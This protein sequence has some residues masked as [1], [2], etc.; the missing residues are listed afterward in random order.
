MLI[1]VLQIST[2]GLIL[3]GHADEFKS[4]AVTIFPR[5]GSPFLP[6]VAPFWVDLNFRD[7]GTVFYRMTDDSSILDAVTSRLH[8]AYS[9]F[10]PTLA[11]VV[12]WFQSRL[13]RRDALV[14]PLEKLPPKLP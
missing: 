5:L 14:R 2:N 4:H 10:T 13:L 11:V 7:Y 8:S 9:E 3:F 12:T 6:L 1:F